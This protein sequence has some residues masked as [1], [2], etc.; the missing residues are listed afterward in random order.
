YVGSA[1][2]KDLKYDWGLELRKHR[3]VYDGEHQGEGRRFAMSK[4]EGLGQVV[5]ALG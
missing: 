4:V 3:E 1:T 2:R 5:S